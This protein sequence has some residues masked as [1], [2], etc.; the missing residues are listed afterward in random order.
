MCCPVP[1]VLTGPQRRHHPERAEQPGEDVGDG[2]T[3]PTCGG[4]PGCR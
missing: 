3:D 4:L 2:P 1:V